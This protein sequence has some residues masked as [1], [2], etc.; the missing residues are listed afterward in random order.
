MPSRADREEYAKARFQRYIKDLL[1]VNDGKMTLEDFLGCLARDG[2]D[3]YTL[4]PLLSKIA[5]IMI[6]DEAVSLRKYQRRI[7][8]TQPPTSTLTE[9]QGVLT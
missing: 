4:A 5:L 2:Y 6:D 9:V 3:V 1:I 8:K 7:P